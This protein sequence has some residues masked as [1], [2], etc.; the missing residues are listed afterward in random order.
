MGKSKALQK[1]YRSVLRVAVVLSRLWP[2]S[3]LGGTGGGERRPCGAAAQLRREHYT[4]LLHS[5]T[6]TTAP[7][8]SEYRGSF[9]GQSLRRGTILTTWIVLVLLCCLLLCMSD[10]LGTR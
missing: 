4:L 6:T 1:G 5:I 3:L 2:V 8:S 10:T 7:G 9:V